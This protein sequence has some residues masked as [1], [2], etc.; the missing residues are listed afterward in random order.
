MKLD[1]LCELDLLRSEREIAESQPYFMSPDTI[2][3]NILFLQNTCKKL[4]AKRD[5]SYCLPT[6]LYYEMQ[7]NILETEKPDRVIKLYETRVKDIAGFEFCEDNLEGEDI[8]EIL[9]NPEFNEDETEEEEKEN[10]GEDLVRVF[11]KIR[12][13]YKDGIITE[14]QR[15]T[16]KRELFVL[17]HLWN[18]MLWW[19][20]EDIQAIKEGEDKRPRTKQHKR[21]RNKELNEK[22]IEGLERLLRNQDKIIFV[23]KE[24]DKYLWVHSVRETALAYF[25]NRLYPSRARWEG[26]EN[27]FGVTNLK[28][29]AY[30]PKKDCLSSDANDWRHAMTIALRQE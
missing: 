25:V 2:Q 24:G 1:I 26:I 8:E 14:D 12:A 9:L 16:I 27:Y 23:K 15:K 22:E 29:T 3:D 11:G 7:A 19:I 28:S 5:L 21:T 10:H 13:L 6:R 17:Y 4:E 18:D 20:W 30:L